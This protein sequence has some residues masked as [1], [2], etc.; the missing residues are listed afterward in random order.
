MPLAPRSVV[1]IGPGSGAVSVDTGGSTHGRGRAEVLLR[2]GECT[3]FPCGGPDRVRSG[4]IVRRHASCRGER[5][6]GIRRCCHLLGIP[7]MVDA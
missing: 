5:R 2:G 7:G 6:D 1:E 3:A 4:A